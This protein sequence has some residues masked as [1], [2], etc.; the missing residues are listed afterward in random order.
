MT[1]D[2]ERPTGPRRWFLDWVIRVCGVITGAALVI[3]A[4]AY[5]RPITKTGPVK[6]RKDVGKASD[7]PVW[8]GRKVEVGGKP[9]IVVRTDSEFVAL[10]AVCTHL[11][12]LVEFNAPKHDIICP[13]HGA[14]FDLTGKVMGG[15]APQPL[16][17][18]QVSVAEGAVY[19]ST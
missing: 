14:I 11:G 6:T 9:V 13:C 16:P 17:V 5:L 19:V 1:G 15:P 3:P 4:I 8:S 2:T 18:Y 12:C 10:S 7:W